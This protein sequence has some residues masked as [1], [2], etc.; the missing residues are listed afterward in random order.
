[1]LGEMSHDSTANT[2][3]YSQDRNQYEQKSKDKRE[4]SSQV[5]ESLR[6]IFS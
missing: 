5:M 2:G 4:E 6:Y 3:T 1:M